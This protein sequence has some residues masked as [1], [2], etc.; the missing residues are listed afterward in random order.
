MK[1]RVLMLF[2]LFIFFLTTVSL[3]ETEGPFRI[4][5]PRKDSQNLP[6]AHL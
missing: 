6:S 2:Q 4:A 3:L 5:T 1:V